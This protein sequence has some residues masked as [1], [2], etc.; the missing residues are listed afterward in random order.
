MYLCWR[1]TFLLAAWEDGEGLCEISIAWV[2][3]T[4]IQSR[5]IYFQCV[6]HSQVL[7]VCRVFFGE[8]SQRFGSKIR[9]QKM[10]TWTRT[11]L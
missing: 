4:R 6:P 3:K 11:C 9:I 2:P 10:C 8:G 7:R 5:F 1:Y